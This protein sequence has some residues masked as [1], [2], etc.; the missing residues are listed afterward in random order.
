[1]VINARHIKY[2]LGHKKNK[3]DSAW[4]CKLLHVGLLKDSFIPSR[5]QRDLCD[6][7]RYRRK[8]VQQQSAEHNRMIRI[9]EDVNL[10]LSS[11]FSNIR[12]KTC[13]TIIDILIK[14]ETALQKLAELCTYWRLKH[15]QEETALAVE[16]YFTKHH[17]F[18][19]SAIHKSIEAELKVLP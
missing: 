14:G 10:K 13:T 12:G 2:V 15:T 11:V 8:L 17:K 6:L 3:K 9:F 1:M 19:A 5:K 7:T 18:I 16:R 4:V